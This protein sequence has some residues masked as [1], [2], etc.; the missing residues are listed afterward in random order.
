MEERPTLRAFDAPNDRRRIVSRADNFGPRFARLM[1]DFAHRLTT[2]LRVSQSQL[3]E[4]T[5]QLSAHVDDFDD[6]TELLNSLWATSAESLP[7]QK[8]LIDPTVFANGVSTAKLLAFSLRHLHRLSAS[9][10]TLIAAA[11]LQDFGLLVSPSTRDIE[12]NSIRDVEPEL[13][14]IH[15]EVSAALASGIELDGVALPMLI[16]GHHNRQSKN[17]PFTS[18]DQQLLAITVAFWEK[19]ER[20]TAKQPSH[21]DAIAKARI[22]GRHL[23]RLS[24]QRTF[25]RRF[26]E[27]FLDALGLLSLS[28]QESGDVQTGIRRPVQAESKIPSTSV[29]DETASD[30]SSVI[31]Q[32]TARRKH[33]RIDA[34]HA[35]LKT[36]A[37]TK[38]R[39]CRIRA[40]VPTRGTGLRRKRSR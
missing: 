4:L 37:M 8:S 2:D 23:L 14:E 40:M 22:A 39:K 17:G 19:F 32:P 25:D 16:R 11:L 26:C 24:D 28:T 6:A 27:S 29:P 13:F 7:V 18:P 33:F 36:P 31:K 5:D 34:P 9:R 38:K 15:P 20:A 3:H 12:F 30:A 1:G 21:H 35:E 10:T